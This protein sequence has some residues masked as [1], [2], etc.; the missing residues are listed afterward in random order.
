MFNAENWLKWLGSILIRRCYNSAFIL[1]LYL[2]NQPFM[3][4]T[5]DGRVF[6]DARHL[7]DDSL[8]GSEWTRIDAFTLQALKIASGEM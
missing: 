4:R 8:A 6:L 3:A 5:S 2:R 7:F 1:I